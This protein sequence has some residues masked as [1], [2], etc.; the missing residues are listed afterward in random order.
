[1]VW[2]WNKSFVFAWSRLRTLR[3]NVSR[4]QNR[5][6]V[7]LCPGLNA[8][9][10]FTIFRKFRS[11]RK[12]RN[13]R[14][15]R[16]FGRG[17]PATL[18]INFVDFFNGLANYRKFRSFRKFRNFRNSRNFGRGFPATLWINFVNSVN[19]LRKFRSFR[20]CVKSWTLLQKSR[21]IFRDVNRSIANIQSLDAGDHATNN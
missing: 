4:K 3:A 1:M 13:F 8:V 15:S 21:F 9:T 14:N 10:N 19:G 16:N 17:F 11:F 2:Y 20:S 18:W 5:T 7:Y 6:E 12:F